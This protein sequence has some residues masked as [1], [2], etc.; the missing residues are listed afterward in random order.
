M[1]TALARAIPALLLP[2]TRPVTRSCNE[3]HHCNNGCC[4]EILGFRG[5]KGR[6]SL[7]ITNRPVGDRM[8]DHMSSDASMPFP[9]L[10]C[11]PPGGVRT[12][13]GSSQ[14]IALGVAPMAMQSGPRVRPG[15]ANAGTSPVSGAI[16]SGGKRSRAAF[17]TSPYHEF[18]REQRPHLPAGMRNSDREKRLGQMWREL[19]EAQRA[20]Y[21]KGLTQLASKGRGGLRCWALDALLAQVGVTPRPEPHEAV[22]DIAAAAETAAQI[23]RSSSAQSIV[24]SLYARGRRAL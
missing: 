12:A 9:S 2:L 18:S 14:E 11:V 20:S 23:A 15:I 19:S 10:A 7:G 3:V 21:R 1:T 22:A 5:P 4:R 16:Q 6:A 13:T 24:G 17:F 8:S